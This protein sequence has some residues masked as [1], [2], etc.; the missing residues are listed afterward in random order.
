MHAAGPSQ[1]VNHELS[2]PDV[3]QLLLSVSCWAM[4]CAT[5]AMLANLPG[6]A[7]R[8]TLQPLSGAGQLA[9]IVGVRCSPARKNACQ[10]ALYQN[11]TQ[12]ILMLRST[13]G[14]DPQLSIARWT[15][16]CNAD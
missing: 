5:G 16:T 1:V 4:A 2:V 15:R 11:I 13:L 7:R 12:P 3:S 8:E 14:S 10:A 6:R 9:A